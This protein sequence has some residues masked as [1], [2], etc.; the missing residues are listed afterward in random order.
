[1]NHKHAS[2]VAL[3][4]VVLLT[5]LTAPA[6]A[7]ADNSTTTAPTNASDPTT[8]PTLVGDSSTHLVDHELR[9]GTM[10]VTLYTTD[11]TRV[12]L[13]APPSSDAERAAGYVTTSRVPAGHKVTVSVRAPDGVVWLSTARQT[14]AGRFTQLD[15]SGPGI[16]PG[17][18]D[19]RDVAYAGAGAAIA[20][21]IS[22]LYE[23]I[24][25]VH[26]DDAGGERVA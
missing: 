24:T 4:V 9:D 18:F 26:G 5:G 19:G 8:A 7:Q 25:A 23:A 15:A 14:S 2:T 6:L 13:S 21:A 10:Y 11:S 20:V 12:S 1:M 17:P 22:V 3:L 16:L